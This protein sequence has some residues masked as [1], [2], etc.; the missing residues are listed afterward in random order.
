MNRLDQL[1][2]GSLSNFEIRFHRAKNPLEI[3]LTLKVQVF[4]ELYSEHMPNHQANFV[5]LFISIKIIRTK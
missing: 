4:D 5:Q 1:K 3:S 2:Q